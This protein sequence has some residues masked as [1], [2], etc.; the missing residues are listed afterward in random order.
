MKAKVNYWQP[1]E[2]G[3]VYHIYDRTVGGVRMFLSERN[4]YYF[5]VKWKELLP[6]LDVYA[7]C[8]LPNHFHFLVRVK[9]LSN[10]LIDHIR[11]QGTSRGEAFIHGDISYSDYLED[12]FKRLLSGYALAL[13][14][15]QKRHGSLFQKRFKRIVVES[16][17]R[18][19]YLLAYIHRNP[20]HHGMVCDYWEWP[21][22][23]YR[24]FLREDDN[25]LVNKVEIFGWFSD[26]SEKAKHQFIDYH[27]EFKDIDIYKGIALE[28]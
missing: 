11:A 27:N 26:D 8:L 12:Q 25:C 6:Y 7:Y 4:Y 1:L 9:Y 18:Q 10:E 28:E 14:K 3:L 20:L 17:H 2:A 16:E 23:S 22:S 21:F 13:N 24:S 19:L 15:Q 5:L